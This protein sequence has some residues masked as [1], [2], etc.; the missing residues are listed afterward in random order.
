MTLCTLSRIALLGVG[1]ALPFA[2]PAV[3]TVDGQLGDGLGRYRLEA[4]DG[5]QPG[6][7]LILYSHGFSMTPAAEAGAPSTAPTDSLRE[8][9]LEQG[10]ALA[11]AG[12]STRGWALFDIGRV[13]I[14]TLD[15][16]A[17]RFGAPGELLLFG[18][19][20]GGQVSLRS[21]EILHA[22]GRPADGVLAACAPA[23]GDRTW[24]QAVDLRLLFDAVCARPLTDPDDSTIP[25]LLDID[26]IPGSI[27]DIDDPDA[28][29]QTLSIA[30]RVRE[31]TGLYQPAVLDSPAQL[32]RR[33]RL[34]TAARIDDDDFLK[35]QLGYAVYPLADLVG[36]AGKLAG[37]SA[38]DNAQVDY[39]DDALNTS[40][41][42][43]DGDRVAAVKLA[44]S[45]NLVGS[46]GDT[47]VLAIHGSADELVFPEY[48]AEL[49]AL[50]HAGARAPVTAMVRETEPAHCGF[51]EREV[52]V[53][54]DA[55]RA[56]IDDDQAPSAASSLKSPYP[57]PSLPVI[58]LN[59]QKVDHSSR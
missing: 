47:R 10:Y 27:D 14:A 12:Y 52:L 20:L 55:L 30:N 8:T 49:A 6:G 50:H 59:A 13:Q 56:W 48:L 53:A 41:R 51:S 37:V 24:N 57:I 39:G 22:A 19:S 42:R 5:W 31:C 45:S 25:W 36:D 16:F 46:W 3:T 28:L 11:A 29:L 54:L 32:E 26:D 35:V 4:P 15:A 7:R 33:Q 18:G 38:F 43:I 40:I 2:A 44:A 17:A 34:K 58:S 21:A 23:G 1:L 9:L